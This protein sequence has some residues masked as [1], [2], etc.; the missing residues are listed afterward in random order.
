MFQSGKW[1]VIQGPASAASS[2]RPITPHPFES[3][4]SRER[5]FEPSAPL[6]LI[7]RQKPTGRLG[8]NSGWHAAE[9]RHASIRSI[10]VSARIRPDC[11]G[12]SGH[13]H[14]HRF[15]TRS[16]LLSQ[17][18]SVNSTASLRLSLTNWCTSGLQR[19]PCNCQACLPDGAPPSPPMMTSHLGGM[20]P[21]VLVGAILY[22]IDFAMAFV[23][24][25][26]K[27]REAPLQ[28]K[29]DGMR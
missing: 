20:A 4:A 12:R 22:S 29:I 25:L 23:H 5:P 2:N 27:T 18:R 26:S 13:R 9:V 16:E 14:R 8:R 1:I 7:I 21:T 3:A 11:V 28:R 6:G 17:S 10:L 19:I 15:S 24:A